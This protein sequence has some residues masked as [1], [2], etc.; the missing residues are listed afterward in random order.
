[1][2]KTKKAIS[3]TLKKAEVQS[4]APIIP[5]DEFIESYSRINVPI[6]SNDII[7]KLNIDWTNILDLTKTLKNI[8]TTLG[9]KFKKTSRTEIIDDIK[10]KYKNEK[11]VLQ[12]FQWPTAFLVGIHYFRN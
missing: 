2:A 6:I 10:V 4:N 8:R 9:G 3:A 7:K 1:M 5:V 11:L 12:E